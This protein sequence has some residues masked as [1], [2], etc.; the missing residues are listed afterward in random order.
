MDYFK[1]NKY[2]SIHENVP[3]IACEIYKIL[4][5]P[6]VL[7]ELIDEYYKLNKLKK[8]SNIENNIK[9]AIIFLYSVG[10]VDYN[11]NIIRRVE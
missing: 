10:K 4:F 11:G 7:D 2:Q 5:K 1:M 6:K 3:Y 8:N 9:L